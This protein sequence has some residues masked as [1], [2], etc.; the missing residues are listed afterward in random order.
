M[1]DFPRLAFV[2]LET[3][4]LNPSAD[5]ITEIGVV[6]VEGDEVSEWSTLVHP[7]RGISHRTQT[8]NGIDEALL[9]GA[10][11]FKEIAGELAEKLSGHL[12]IAHNARF[13]YSFLR[14]AF[15]RVGI[16]FHP[17]VL[18][19]VMLSRKLY[20]G[21][22]RH[23]LDSVMQRCGLQAEMRHR[24]LPDARLLWQFWRIVHRDHPQQSIADAISTLLAGPVFPAHLDPSLIERL[25]K[26]PGIYVLH[27]E[28][29]VLQVGY[30]NNLRIHVQ[31][32]F[33]IDRSSAKALA[34]SQL[35]RNITW[36][37][38]A[39]PLGARLQLSM[40][41]K[42]LLPAKQREVTQGSYSWR[43]NPD[44]YPSIELISETQRRKSGCESYGL[45]DSERKARN[46]LRR[47]AHDKRLCY[48]LLGLAE[49]QEQLCTACDLGPE[50]GRCGR[51][52]ERL[53]HLT[54]VIEA[55][56]PLRVPAWP[57]AGP[58]G[59]RERA[60]IHIVH[61]W[62]YLGTA[63]SESEIDDVLQT[64]AS[65]FDRDMFMLLAKK[66]PR[67]AVWRIIRLP[68]HAQRRPVPE[69]ER[70]AEIA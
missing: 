50:S 18:C 53:K 43:L 25:P 8:Y 35:V 21:H 13:D 31:N 47:V 37:V 56:A 64:R 23:D 10:P 7:R 16:E 46:A 67:L 54:R 45:Y 36:R 39:G 28:H 49:T 63:R 3:T 17:Q 33:R 6:T 51:R 27:G 65:D 59:I 58:I 68:D 62:R 22:A 32:Y 20:T 34:V 41:S 66:L 26:A 5:R 61:D 14:A 70:Y 4:G 38:A 24:A 12:F 69:F 1:T 40:L 44:R 11:L 57:F 15:D 9:V 42:S 30:A 55:L 29:K 2:D 48:A 60:D 52:I 19:S